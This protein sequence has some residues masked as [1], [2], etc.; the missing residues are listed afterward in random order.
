CRFARGTPLARAVKARTPRPV[1]ARKETTFPNSVD[2]PHRKQPNPASP[3]PPGNLPNLSTA[4]TSGEENPPEPEVARAV[5]LRRLR[6]RARYRSRRRVVHELR[7]RDHSGRRR[8]RARAFDEES[9]GALSARIRDPAGVRRRG[10]HDHERTTHGLRGHP[11]VARALENRSR[12]GDSR[13]PSTAARASTT[14]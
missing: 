6:A 12:S 11:P 9:H 5:R 8:A 3:D 4:G 7:R 2:T 14:S 13:F 10:G 1:P